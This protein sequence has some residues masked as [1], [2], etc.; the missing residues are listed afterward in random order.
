M[1]LGQLSVVVHAGVTLLLLVLQVADES[2]G[3][4]FGLFIGLVWL[5]DGSFCVKLELGQLNGV[6][7]G[8]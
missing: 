2:N 3:N 4:L 7:G 8:Y 5:M 1:L 6:D